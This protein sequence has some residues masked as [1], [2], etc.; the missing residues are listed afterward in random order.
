VF[1]AEYTGTASTVVGACFTP[2]RL[3]LECEPAYPSG[4]RTAAQSRVHAVTHISS[5]RSRE[6]RARDRQG[7]LAADGGRDPRTTVANRLAE[8]PHRADPLAHRPASAGLEFMLATE[9]PTSG[10]RRLAAGVVTVLFA[11]FAITVT[12]GLTFA[13][14]HV[15]V[16]IDAFVPVLAAVLFVNDLI[17]ATLLYGQFSI[18]RSRA[19][20]VV[21]NAYLF[22]GFMAVLFALTFPGQ[23]STNGLLGAGLQT[24]AWIYNFWHYGFPLA[25]IV[26]AILIGAGPANKQSNVSAS[27]AVARSVAAVI[28]VVFAL[29]WLATA[30]EDWLPRLFT[31]PV[32]PTPLARIVTTSN[33]LVCLFALVLLNSRRR[34]ILDLWLTV[35][36]CAWI[37]ELAMLDVLLYSRYTFGFY[38]GRGFSL[39]TSV[40]VLVV[41]LQE[42][43]QLYARLARSNG[44]LQRERSNRFMNLEAMAASIAHEINQPLAA[45]VTNGGIGLLLLG[46]PDHDRNEMQEVLKR[47]VDDG[48]RASEVISS[49]RAMFRRD[50]REKSAVSIRDLVHEVLALVR[51][52]LINHG[53]SLRVEL[54]PDLPPIIADRLQLRQVLVNLIMNAIEAMSSMQDDERS[55]LVKCEL[56]ASRGVVIMVEDSGPGIDPND[57]DRIFDAFFTTK[58]HGTGLGLSICR[59][60]VE[61]HDGRLWA[62]DRIPRGSTFFV[63]LPSGAPVGE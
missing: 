6:S 22:T 16:R 17:T 58:P 52:E 46:R 60:I 39:I 21:A 7:P 62:S 29:T 20:L 42:M 28:A 13:F 43:T 14:A 12:V 8:N 30:G 24:A 35:V 59:S 10:Q 34:S 49:V 47:I 27:V 51:G 38:A 56:H 33:T 1:L 5:E 53:V 54:Q 37:S 9:P 23:F 3:H 36:L 57:M 31:D 11:V 55:L 4:D 44:A 61:S 50:R 26:Y 63:Q 25:L 18:I 19:L 15:P 40:V 2:A 32:H 45:L 41:F 48:H